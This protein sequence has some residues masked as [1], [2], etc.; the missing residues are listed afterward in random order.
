MFGLARAGGRATEGKGW[1]RGS[2]ARIAF[3]VR[4]RAARRR[5]KP[6]CSL[7][8]RPADGPHLQL[9][10]VGGALPSGHGD[11]GRLREQRAKEQQ[12]APVDSPVEEAE[13]EVVVHEPEVVEPRGLRGVAASWPARGGGEGGDRPPP[14]RAKPSTAAATAPPRASSGVTVSH[15]FGLQPFC[16]TRSITGACARPQRGDRRTEA[17]AAV[18]RHLAATVHGGVRSAPAQAS[19]P[20]AVYH[21]SPPHPSSLPSACRIAKRKSSPLRLRDSLRRGGGVSPSSGPRAACAC[22]RLP[23]RRQASAPSAPR[24]R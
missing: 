8:T 4:A 15:M 9:V 11:D 18:G 5:A 24:A 7:P 12:H 20:C 6:A 21:A 13:V 22:A 3:R 23:A 19:G 1:R 14:A 16:T 2:C 17:T 10:P